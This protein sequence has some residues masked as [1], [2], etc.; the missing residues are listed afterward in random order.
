MSALAAIES[1]TLAF[2]ATCAG[3]ALAAGVVLFVLAELAT[4]AWM[5]RSGPYFV[6]A[7][8]A[9]TRLELDRDALPSL[10]PLAHWEIN[11][12]GE[13]GSEPPADPART[14]RVLVT[15]GSAAE[16]YFL[17]QKDTW[18]EVV[19]RELRRPEALRALGAE[20]VHV[21]NAARSL[22]AC[23]EIELM[24]R[25]TLPRYERLDVVVF[26]VGASDVV[27]WLEKSTP[28][29]IEEKTIPAAQV[30]AWHPEGPF[31]WGPR[32]L[33]LRRIASSWN[34]RLRRPVEV[35]ERAGKRLDDARKMRQ[36]AKVVLDATPD[37]TP[38]LEH[39]ETHL[40]ALVE[41]CRAKGARVVIARQPWLEKA[42]TPEER[43]RLWNF[44]AGRPYSGEVTTYYAHEAVWKLLAQ[45]DERAVRVAQELG[46][47]AL[48]LNSLVPQDFEHYYDELHHTPKGC[49]L[50]GR[51]VARQIVAGRA[52]PRVHASAR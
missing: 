11:S 15:G 39:F 37:P 21:G 18:A 13:R 6:W 40:R 24:L 19:G 1:S 34:K 32:T 12:Q 23:A 38:M 22:V 49:E 17:D 16:C 35:R 5:I 4:R 33:A 46:V 7:P 50:L 31:G 45:V 48:E 2:L 26:L 20:H 25:R 28:A 30:F 3:V 41:L 43:A 44:G 42:L 52:A 47:E 36:R 51:A 27:H 10:P 14:Y 29:R 9:R 8:F